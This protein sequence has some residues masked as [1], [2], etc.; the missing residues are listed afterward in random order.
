MHV[1]VKYLPQMADATQRTY[2]FVAIDRATRWVYL[3]RLPD[4]SA[5]SARGFLERLLD[6]APFK[7]RT[8]LTDNGKEFTDRFCA[9]GEREPTGRH[10]VDR[11]CAEHA[12]DHRLIKPAHPQTNGMVERF[13]GRIAEVLTTNRFRC[14]EHLEDTLQRSAALYNHHLPQRNLGHV[15]PVQALA[16][17]HQKQPDL[18]LSDPSNLPG[19]D[20]SL[21][22]AGSSAGFTR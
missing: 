5:H 20:M 18:V 13:N 12:I 14:D 19:P 22:T 21:T 11:R 8:V 17:W 15:S 10:L 16:Q 1:D 9:T 4:K 2:L 6:A 7:L 3:E